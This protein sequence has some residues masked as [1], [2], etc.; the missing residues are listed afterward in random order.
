MLDVVTKPLL[1]SRKLNASVFFD[2]VADA[3]GANEVHPRRIIFIHAD[4]KRTNDLRA[5]S[6]VHSAR[7]SKPSRKAGANS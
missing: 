1:E 3:A 5:S 6:S 4:H 2:A 7:K